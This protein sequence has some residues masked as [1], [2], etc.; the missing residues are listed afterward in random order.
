M[1]FCLFKKKFLVVVVYI[2][3]CKKELMI[4]LKKKDKKRSEIDKNIYCIG[5]LIVILIF[6]S[7]GYRMNCLKSIVLDFLGWLFWNFCI[8]VLRS[9][10]EGIF[11][12]ISNFIIC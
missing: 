1:G 10:R 2:K 4:W 3:K 11:L 6:V 12:V 5:M 7:V 9:R 8:E